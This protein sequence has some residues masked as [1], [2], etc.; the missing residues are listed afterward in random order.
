MGGIKLLI[1]V[2][3]TLQWIGQSITTPQAFPSLWAS[4]FIW[5]TLEHLGHL[6]M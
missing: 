3:Y 5:N 1:V 2:T 4:L 6:Q